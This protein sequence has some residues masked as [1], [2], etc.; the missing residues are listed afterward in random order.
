M[1]FGPRV[2]AAGSSGY[3]QPTATR[4][5]ARTHMQSTCSS[6]LVANSSCIVISQPTA[7][8]FML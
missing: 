6:L 3:T 5:R 2:T 8:D 4:D 1:F 7:A